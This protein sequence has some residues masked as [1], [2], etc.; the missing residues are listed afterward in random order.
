MAKAEG[1][2]KMESPQEQPITDVAERIYGEC[3]NC[4]AKIDKTRIHWRRFCS[5]TCRVQ[6]HFRARK[7][8]DQII[9]ERG[10]RG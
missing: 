6:Y 4:A 2:T 10:N 7:L 3:E 5:D 8:G 9:K 1:S